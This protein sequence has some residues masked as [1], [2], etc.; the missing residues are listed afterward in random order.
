MQQLQYCSWSCRGQHQYSPSN[1]RV[2]QGHLT[3]PENHAMIPEQPKHTSIAM[4]NYQNLVVLHNGECYR[5]N[6]TTSK[7]AE[8]QGEILWNTTPNVFVVEIREHLD[9]QNWGN[10]YYI[11][12]V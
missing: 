3:S 7:T 11:R 9:D 8:Q 1:G 6:V 10:D 2:P 5:T 4:K 12:N